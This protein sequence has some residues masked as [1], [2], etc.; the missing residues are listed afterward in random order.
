[1]IINNIFECIVQYS[2]IN[3]NVMYIFHIYLFIKEVKKKKK[4]IIGN[5]TSG[6]K[7]KKI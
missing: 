7:N 3:R 4:K 1:M 2:D 6:R 5:F